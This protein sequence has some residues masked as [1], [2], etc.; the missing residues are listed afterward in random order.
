MK[1]LFVAL[2]CGLFALPA[3]AADKKKIVFVAGRESHG[4]MAHNH[5][6]GCKLLA[7]ALEASG[8]P[9]ETDIC[10]GGYPSDPETYFKDADAV[11]I[12][13]DGG[14]GHVLNPNLALF[15]KYMKKGVGLCCIHYAVETPK[16]EPGDKFLDWLGG[17]F[18]SNWSVNPHWTAEFK[19]FPNH[20]IANGVKPFSINDEWYFHMRF[21]PGLA[22][23]TPILS[24]LAPA[25]TMKR[26]DGAHSGNPDVRKSVAAG[27]PQH[28]GWA[29]ERQ[30]GGRGFGFTGGHNHQN[31]ANDEF[32]KVVLNA[33]AWIAKVDVPKDGVKSKTPEIVPT[34]KT[35]PAELQSK[36]VS[37]AAKKKGAAVA[38]SGMPSPKDAL[39]SSKVVT[40]QTPGQSVDIQANLKGAKELYLVAMDGGDGFGCDWANWVEPVLHGSY[41]QK[42]LTDLSWKS[43]STGYG[44]VRMNLNNAG[45]PMM[46]SGKSVANGLGVHANSVIAYD[47]PAG[48]ER[49]TARGA[50]DDGGTK[51]GCGSTVQFMVFSKKPKFATAVAKTSGG[52][53]AS[54]EA[55]SAVEQLEVHDDLEATLWAAEPMLM[56]P[57]SIDVDAQ[58]R[59]WVCE[60][61]N[62]RRHKGKRPEGDRILVLEDTNTDGKADKSTVF[63]QGNEV[64]TAHGVAVLGSQVI[65]SVGD[66]VIRFEDKNGDLKADGPPVAMFTGISG[67]QHDHGIH[68]FMFGPDGKLYFNFGNAGNQ[69]KDA[70]GKPI[71]DMAGNEV[72]HSRKPYQEGMVFRCNLD[73]S[74]FETLGWNFRNNWEVTV[75]SFGTIW[76]SD[77]DDDGNRGV[78]INYVMEFGNFGYKDEKTGQNWNTKRTNIETEK[79]LMHWHLNDPG[80]V[81][82]LLQTGAGSPTGIVIYEGNL[83]PKTFQGQI[84]HCDAGPSITRAYPVTR[85]GAGYAAETV[86]ILDGAP[87]NKWFRPSDVSVMPDGALMVADWYDPGVGGHNMQELERGRLF[88]V[89]PKGNKPA[90]AKPDFSSNAGLAKALM[91]PTAATRYLAWTALH[92]KGPAAESALAP[93]LNSADSR[94]RAR[95]IWLLG[96]VPGQGAKWVDLAAKDK[97]SDIRTVAIRLAR[98]LADVDELDVVKQLIN[99]PS[100][101]VRR[102]G[103]IALRAHQTTRSAALW[104]ELAA[105]HDGKDR[106][107]L[108]ALGIGSDL[109]ADACLAAWLNKVGNKWNASAGKDIVWRSRSKDACDLLAKIVK[110]SPAEEH[111][112]Y[113]RAFDF[114]KGPEKDKALAS[115]L[116]L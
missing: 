68:A 41:G 87:M 80:V 52:G 3:F 4:P 16:G 95:A 13:C 115:I 74:A 98:Q 70:D 57:S 92:A 24:A 18:E 45:K 21:R 38:P 20:P 75:D 62:Y 10:I 78:R 2:F 65:V 66:K 59:V 48:T 97:D 61:V 90:A 27:E 111:P 88:R 107:Y 50:L 23:V 105:Q 22:G 49:L 82:N 6:Q 109:N 29:T 37:G 72:N 116:G 108:E 39:F 54:H 43:A 69:I 60:V 85:D 99:D 15:D 58:G 5:W 1:K 26:S 35:L 46:V 91:S 42:K 73:G 114:H 104:A 11:V 83:L 32:R 31:W 106:W 63:F 47:L 40:A 81:P 110:S 84:I 103:A 36:A 93:L 44:Q 100:A 17:F 25:E 76:Q 28:L 77:N 53:Q 101:Q 34:P 55:A 96:K 67:T 19:T 8:L 89:A 102:E 86:N 94:M 79:P 12:Y 14:G 33:L 71:I 56:N 64:D 51:Q 30:D 7:D 112:R 9:I 113:M